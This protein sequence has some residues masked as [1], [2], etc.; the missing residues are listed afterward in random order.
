MVVF[1]KRQPSLWWEN[2]LCRSLN[3]NGCWV[4]HRWW[5]GNL[6]P[7][8]IYTICWGRRIWNWGS[9]GTW[10]S[11]ISWHYVNLNFDE[12]SLCVWSQRSLKPKTDMER[13]GGTYSFLSY[14]LSHLLACLVCLLTYSLVVHTICLLFLHFNNESLLKSSGK[15]KKLVITVLRVT[16]TAMSPSMLFTEY[17]SQCFFMHLFTLTITN[18]HA[19]RSR[20]DGGHVPNL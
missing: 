14:F 10:S 12:W 17:V 15:P 18:H 1:S 11:N 2:S 9:A 3:I 5:N 6:R 7:W 16:F 19:R 20:W 13:V 4:G 8:R